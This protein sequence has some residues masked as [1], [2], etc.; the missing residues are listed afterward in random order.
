MSITIV[1]ISA[2]NSSLRVQ[3]HVKIWLLYYIS[4]H[5]KETFADRL[6]Y[7]NTLSFE[8]VTERLLAAVSSGGRGAKIKTLPPCQTLKKLKLLLAEAFLAFLL[9]MFFPLMLL[10][11][12]R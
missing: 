6:K 5:F 12:Q 3:G 10:L 7:P 9:S 2:G 8:R 11:F 4:H 1:K